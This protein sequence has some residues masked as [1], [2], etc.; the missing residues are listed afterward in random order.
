MRPGP[1]VARVL[2][3][4]TV[5]AWLHDEKPARRRFESLLDEAESGE[6]ELLMNMVNVGEVFYLTARRFGSA[7]AR[8]FWEDFQTSPVRIVP[9]P[10]SLILAAAEWKSRYAIS[11][12]DAFA[13]ATAVR[14]GAVLVTG[15]ADFRPLAEDGVVRLEWLGS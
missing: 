15:D 4:W 12:A 6:T 10:D 11:Y 5:M 7:R 9:A 1:A 8:R 13:V 2:D 14:E 3:S